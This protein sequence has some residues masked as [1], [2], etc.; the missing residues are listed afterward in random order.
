MNYRHI[1]LHFSPTNVLLVKSRGNIFISFGIIKELP[2]L[3]GS[4]TPYIY[5]APCKARNFNVIYIYMDLRLATLKVVF[6]YLLHNVSSLNQ[7]RKFP[8]SQLCVNVLTATK[9]TLIRD[10]I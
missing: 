1:P 5:G 4:R 3:I 2:G 8:V 9:V 6:F 10:G 7:C